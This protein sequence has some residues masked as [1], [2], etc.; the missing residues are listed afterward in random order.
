MI[1]TRTPYR[2]SLMGGGTDFPAFFREHGG[3]VISAALN[4]HFYIGMTRRIDD[5]IALSYTRTEIVQTASE[6]KHDLVRTILAQYD[7]HS[8]WEI[9]ML[10][11]ILGGTGL[12]SSSAVSIGLLH[13]VRTWL[14]LECGA[15]LLAREAVVVETELLQK[16]I[17]WQ[18]QYGVAFPAL[19]QIRFDR[20]AT[21]HVEPIALTPKNR[22]A[23]ETHTLLVYTGS[24][25]KAESVLAEQS[26]NTDA[27][28]SGL[29]T[30][31]SMTRELLAALQD[32]PLDLPLIGSMISESWQIKRTFAAGIS[33]PKVDAQYQAGIAS[34][35]WGGKL[36]GAGA[37]G[38]LL[39]VISPELQAAMLSRMGNPPA[40]RLSLDT[41]GSQLVY[42]SGSRRNGAYWAV[43]E[44]QPRQ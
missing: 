33:N 22:T 7:L 19:K 14:D 40:F 35:A 26:A 18:D 9:G 17:G 1:I 44:D 21:V 25:R 10:G 34:G 36:L 24:V 43:P 29:E 2:V 37:G 5:R 38:F 28:L 12:G 27:N 11:E 42:D 41:T 30:L 23:L 32:S 8:G 13:A 39:F 6:L 4:K 15:D 16:C 20:D 31:C 3:L